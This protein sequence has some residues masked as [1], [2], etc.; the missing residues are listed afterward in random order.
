VEWDDFVGFNI[1]NV[2]HNVCQVSGCDFV[3]HFE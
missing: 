1:Q 3:G 2:A